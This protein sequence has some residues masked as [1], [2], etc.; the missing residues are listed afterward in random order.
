MILGV[1]LARKVYPAMKYLSVMLI[2]FGV[3]I[4]MYNKEKSKAKEGDDHLMGIGE[5]LVVSL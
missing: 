3:A 2:V 5:M 4:F 1:I